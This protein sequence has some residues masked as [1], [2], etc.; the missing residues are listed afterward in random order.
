MA[1]LKRHPSRPRRQA[2][3]LSKPV[4][5][6]LPSPQPQEKSQLDQFS[7]LPVGKSIRP[8]RLSLTLQSC[9]CSLPAAAASPA[10]ELFQ[11]F[12]TKHFTGLAVMSQLVWW[13]VLWVKVNL[14]KVKFWCSWPLKPM[15]HFEA[16]AST[17]T[18]SLHA[19]TFL[20]R[21]TVDDRPEVSPEIFL[22]QTLW[23]QG[24]ED[25]TFE[26]FK[27]SSQKL[28][29]SQ[30]TWLRTTAGVKRGSSYP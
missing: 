28:N 15:F 26:N 10:T 14:A 17:M 2:S 5:N 20:Q 9:L 29:P 4:C 3:S 22:G 13:Y 25:V 19:S 6:A 24:G 21:V 16:F 27:F 1:K 7:W 11:T 30:T 12:L 8:A 23:E 18:C